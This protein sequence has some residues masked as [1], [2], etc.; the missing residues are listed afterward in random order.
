MRRTLSLLPLFFL[1]ACAAAP[2]GESIRAQYEDLT[3]AS[4]TVKILSDIGVSALEYQGDYQYN[5][6][7]E[8]I[9]TMT[10]PEEVAGIEI[11]IAG[12]AAEE[13][14]LRYADP[15]LYLALDTPSGTR[16][17]DAASAV[18]RTLRT[19]EPNAIGEDLLD[20]IEA[21]HLSYREPDSDPAVS[22]E[23]WLDAQG[24]PLCAEI[25]VDGEKQVTL[26]FTDF[27]AA[28]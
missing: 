4:A 11:R 2:S 14:T 16:P 8:D 24:F 26:F 25:F 5:K 22:R 3:A 23:I 19:A 21:Q 9:L 10:A 1:C 28:P 20:G 7:G 15:E 6:D 13:Y 17:V 12:G 18:L 27:T